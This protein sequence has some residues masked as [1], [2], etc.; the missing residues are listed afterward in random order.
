M[1]RHLTPTSNSRYSLGLW[2]LGAE[3]KSEAGASVQCVPT[4]SRAGACERGNNLAHLGSN[5]RRRVT[6]PRVN[7]CIGAEGQDPSEW[8]LRHARPCSLATS[9]GADP[10][11]CRPWSLSIDRK[12]RGRAEAEPG[13]GVVHRQGTRPMIRRFRLSRT[14]G[15][16]EFMVTRRWSCC[17]KR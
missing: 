13:K 6:S 17:A 12:C 15:R 5:G 7:A 10:G 4:Q 8:H 9:A 16:H 11:H 14:K 3:Q 1:G 2:T